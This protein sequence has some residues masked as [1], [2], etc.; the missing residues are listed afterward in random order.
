M[1]KRIKNLFDL[2]LV[3]S[4]HITAEYEGELVIAFPRF[5]SKLMKKYF[6]KAVIINNYL[7]QYLI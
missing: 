5:R 3:I 2:I 1:T 7:N 6:T 4:E